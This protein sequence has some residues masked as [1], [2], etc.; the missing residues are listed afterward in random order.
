[1]FNLAVL[2]ALYPRFYVIKSAYGNSEYRFLTFRL[3]IRSQIGSLKN[4]STPNRFNHA[5]FFLQRFE[6][7][8]MVINGNRFY[9]IIGK[10][11]GKQQI[12]F[13]MAFMIGAQIALQRM[14]AV[15]G[16]DG[17]VVNQRVEHINQ[18]CH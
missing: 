1:M 15:L 7:I 8:I 9:L 3:P 11:I 16:G 6:Q 12:G 5:L 13:E 14:V 17:R 10:L 2:F 18:F 4:L